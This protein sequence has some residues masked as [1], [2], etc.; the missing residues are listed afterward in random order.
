MRHQSLNEHCCCLLVAMVTKFGFHSNHFIHMIFRALAHPEYCINHGMQ[1]MVG[2]RVVSGNS[3][4]M[5]TF[6]IMHVI[7]VR[8]CFI[9]KFTFY[10]TFCLIIHNWDRKYKTLIAGKVAQLILHPTIYHMPWFIQYP[11]CAR[12]FYI[13]VAMV[14]KIWLPW[15]PNI[16]KDVFH[17]G[18]STY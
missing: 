18:S 7:G 12:A 14:T 16:L 4:A 17:W 9:Q 10:N 11:G 1:Y 3:P 5:R 13:L 8:K 6:Q 2:L 15:Q